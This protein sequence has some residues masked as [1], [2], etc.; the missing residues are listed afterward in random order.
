MFAQKNTC[1]NK[2]YNS[3][4]EWTITE[5]VLWHEERMKGVTG[6]VNEHK[7]ARKVHKKWKRSNKNALGWI[8]WI[9]MIPRQIY[10]GVHDP[11]HYIYFINMKLNFFK[12]S[13]WDITE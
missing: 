5:Y 1:K 12:E 6:I 4:K 2:T 10:E 9:E 11:L 13:P 7:R 3:K 8:N